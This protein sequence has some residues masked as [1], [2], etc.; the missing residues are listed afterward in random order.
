MSNFESG[1]IGCNC[2]KCEIT[3]ADNRAVQYFRCGCEDCRQGMEWGQTHG[4]VNPDQLPH[5]YYI[6]ADIISVKGKEFMKTFVLREDGR[7]TRLYCGECWSLIAIEH[8]SSNHLGVA[9]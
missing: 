8:P 5:A 3:V 1:T 2:G 9:L 7:S 6:P 4:G